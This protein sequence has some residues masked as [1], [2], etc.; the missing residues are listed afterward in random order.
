MKVGTRIPWKRKKNS[1]SRI[2]TKHILKDTS[3]EAIPGRTM[4]VMGPSGCG[5]TS[6]LNKMS[7]RIQSRKDS[8]LTGEI[9]INDKLPLNMVTFS[10]IGGYVMQDDHLFSFFTPKEALTF[11]ARLKL[12]KVS[13]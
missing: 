13:K 6:L 12:Y 10:K 1:K 2:E 9:M 7:D 8:I 11:A 4:F 5:K 3:G